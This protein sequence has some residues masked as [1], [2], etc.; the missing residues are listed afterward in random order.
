MNGFAS[1]EGCPFPT[2]VV[3]RS[4]RLHLLHYDVPLIVAAAALAANVFGTFAAVQIARAREPP[5]TLI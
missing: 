5:T 3:R 2:S 1:R 4:R